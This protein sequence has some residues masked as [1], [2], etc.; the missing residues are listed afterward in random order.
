MKLSINPGQVE[1]YWEGFVFKGYALWNKLNKA[2]I[3]M[4]DTPSLN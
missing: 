4:G 2:Y 3:H 1:G